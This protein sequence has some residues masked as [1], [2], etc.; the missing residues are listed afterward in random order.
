[1]VSWL[2]PETAH[3]Y[4]YLEGIRQLSTTSS[5]LPEDTVTQPADQT[6]PLLLPS[7]VK[8]LRYL[9]SLLA[10]R[11]A[12]TTR[13]ARK[14]PRGGKKLEKKNMETERRLTQCR[15]DFIEQRRYDLA[16]CQYY[17]PSRSICIYLYIEGIRSSRVERLTSRAR[18]DWEVHLVSN[19]DVSYQCVFMSICRS[20]IQGCVCLACRARVWREAARSIG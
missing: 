9:A 4:R 19:S 17:T 5:R 1:M 20:S 6:V 11:Q 18:N 14:N 3:V 8:G 12:R 13:S 15:K 16:A 10:V 7:I 2:L